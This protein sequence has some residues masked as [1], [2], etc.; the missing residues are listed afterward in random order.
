MGT[1]IANVFGYKLINEVDPN[2]RLL[3]WSNNAT[4]ELPKDRPVMA[5]KELKRFYCNNCSIHSIYKLSFTMLPQLT[6]LELNYNNLS[7]I[8]PDAFENNQMLHKVTLIGNNLVKFNPEAA[9]RHVSQV[10]CLM[11]DQNPSF[12][13]NEV[14]IE[15][16]W[17]TY[18][19]CKHCNTSVIEKS[20]MSRW[21]RLV[22]LR[23][24]YNN[25]NQIKPDAFED[26]IRL[27]YLNV[28]GNSELKEL[29]FKSKTILH[30]S[31][32]KCGL[33][34]KLDTSSLEALEFINV[35][36]NSISN[37]VEH[38]FFNN[39]KI[40]RVLLDD[41]EIQKIPEKLLDL[42]LYDLETLCID[43]NPLQPRE[44][45]HNFTVKYLARRLR[46]G[47]SRASSAGPRST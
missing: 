15:L 47:R 3:D 33:E 1:H 29:A 35:R 10:S 41:N 38:G 9:L 4:F 7:Y 6:Y 46:R 19:S 16:P 44:L 13:I 28:D 40:K 39:K 21:K 11:I 31:A 43:R 20:T 17:L 32:E 30:L 18:F 37:L 5:L 45:L 25:I 22:H 26:P 8:H 14:T 23:L 34:G 42:P 27:K 2:L 24:S 36:S 12:D